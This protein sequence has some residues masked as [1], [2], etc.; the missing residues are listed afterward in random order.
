MGVLRYFLHIIDTL[1]CLIGWFL[2]L[3]DDKHQTISDKI[4]KTLVLTG[5]P[6]QA[7]GP[8]VFKP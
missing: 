4:V 5:A 7:F 1:A 6:K 8:D 2:P 3:F